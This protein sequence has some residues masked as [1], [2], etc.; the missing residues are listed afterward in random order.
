MEEAEDGAFWRNWEL[1]AK[2]SRLQNVGTEGTF[3]RC[4]ALRRRNTLKDLGYT[5]S[6]FC[7]WT[8]SVRLKPCLET[9]H[10]GHSFI[11]ISSA[12]D[13]T[14]WASN[15]VSAAEQKETP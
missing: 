12:R 13:K 6:G 8:V 9:G 5:E 15:H 1:E 14:M 2:E 4:Y 10:T 11:N 7:C 3:E